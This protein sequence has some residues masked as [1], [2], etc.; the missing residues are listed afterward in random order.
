MG[1]M[2]VPLFEETGAGSNGGY[3]GHGQRVGV[4]SGWG[5]TTEIF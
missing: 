3:A 4:G 1:G 2:V 5:I